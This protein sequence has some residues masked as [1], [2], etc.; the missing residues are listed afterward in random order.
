MRKRN[1]S[2]RRP[3]FKGCRRRI[4]TEST[5]NCDSNNDLQYLH[6]HEVA[7]PLVGQF[8]RHHDCHPLLLLVAGLDGVNEQIDFPVRD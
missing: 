5:T 3:E 2:F 8:V 7:E 1:A 4:W 6:G